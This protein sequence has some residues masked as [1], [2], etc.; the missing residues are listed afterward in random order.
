MQSY[1][2]NTPY[3]NGHGHKVETH[4]TTF[5]FKDVFGHRTLGVR[6][7]P[8]GH[9]TRR[10]DGRADDMTCVAKSKGETAHVDDGHVLVEFV[11]ND[12]QVCNPS[13]L[14]SYI[15]IESPVVLRG[16]YSSED[17]ILM[18]LS[19]LTRI[20]SILAEAEDIKDELYPES[21]W[22]RF[23]RFLQ[24]LHLRKVNE[25]SIYDR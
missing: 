11:T 21:Q 2:R 17:M 4:S 8:K 12:G 10:D 14:E 23:H 3:T 5:A 16:C 22:V 20:L 1:I 7:L 6:V 18:T 9:S 24:P 19:L 15:S 25:M 13:T